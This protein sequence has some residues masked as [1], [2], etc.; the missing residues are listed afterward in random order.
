MSGAH[1]QLTQ[2][3]GGAAGIII[4]R[5]HIIPFH[6]NILWLAL[7]LVGLVERA[8]SQSGN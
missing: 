6:W 3:Y 2:V 4:F 7:F 1:S 8:I 5:T